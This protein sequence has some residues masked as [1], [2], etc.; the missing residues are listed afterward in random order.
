MVAEARSDQ[1]RSMPTNRMASHEK[2]SLASSAHELQRAAGNLQKHAADPDAVPT[3]GITLAHIEEALDRLSVGMRRMPNGVVVWCGEEGLPTDE[4]A[5]GPQ[6][7]ALCFHLRAVAD[8]LRAARDAC[9]STRMWTRRLLETSPDTDREH[10][11]SAAAS[12]EL[13]A[14]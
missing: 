14:A 5:L 1:D 4:D 10:C 13:E 11:S 3:L 12:E 2:C 6:A 8:G 7:R 9:T